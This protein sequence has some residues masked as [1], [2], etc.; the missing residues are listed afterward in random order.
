MNDLGHKNFDKN[1]YFWKNDEVWIRES[2]TGKEG[3]VEIRTQFSVPKKSFDGFYQHLKMKKISPLNYP[4][5]NSRS[6]VGY[7]TNI[8]NFSIEQMTQ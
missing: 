3:F 1:A 7:G 5:P 2:L 4:H 6:I 8:A